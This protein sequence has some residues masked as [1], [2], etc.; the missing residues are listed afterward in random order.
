M[1]S[2]WWQGEESYETLRIQRIRPIYLLDELHQRA[3]IFVFKLLVRL[4]N[5]TCPAEKPFRGGW[6]QVHTTVTLGMTKVVMSV[7]AMQRNSGF[8]DVHDPRHAGQ[9]K[10]VGGDVACGHVTGRTFVIGHE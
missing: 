6:T 4:H 3:F 1:E 5:R 7:R 2:G 9:I 8:G 10:T